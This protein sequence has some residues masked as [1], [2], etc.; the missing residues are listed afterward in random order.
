M[1]VEGVEPLLDGVDVVVHAAARLASS[2]QPLRHRLVAHVK[3]QHALTRSHLRKKD[4]R[5]LVL[6]HFQQLRSYHERDRNAETGEK[7]V[8]LYE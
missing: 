2:Q 1:F 6:R 5:N 4:G 3:V 8:S 7:I